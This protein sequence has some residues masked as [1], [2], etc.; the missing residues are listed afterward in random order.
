[1]DLLSHDILN[2]N[3]ATLSYLELI[4]SRPGDQGKTKAFA[5]VA[6][7]QVRT[8]SML[9]DSIRRFVKSARTGNMPVA[10][11]SLGDMFSSVADEVSGLFPHKNVTIDSSGLG[12]AASARG[13]Q[14]V[15]DIFRNLLANLVQLSPKDDVRIE[16][17]ASEE[18]RE[19]MPYW[20]VTVTSGSAVI[21]QGL[22]ISVFERLR[23]VDVSK[24]ARVSG[25][26][27]AGSIARALGGGLTARVPDREA[28]QGCS[29]AVS[30]KGAEPP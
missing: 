6:A 11:V 12:A 21:P 20:V 2:K 19:S 15:H 7:S 3:Q 8:S 22:D 13:A 25:I 18:R 1:M 27:F 28:G 5:E 26:V 4:S 23:G 17:A 29:F 24:M 14:C 30:L 9:L 10:P 16:I